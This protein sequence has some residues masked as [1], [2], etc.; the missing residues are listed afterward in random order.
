M[1]F[2][3][4]HFL[5]ASELAGAFSQFPQVE[6]IA[7]GGSLSGGIPDISSDIDLYVFTTALIPLANREAIVQK[8]GASRANLNLTFWDLGDEWFDAPSGIELDIIYWDINW[9][10]GMLDQTLVRQQAGMGY[11]TCFWR[12]LKMAQALFDRSGWLAAQQQ[13]C[14]V[15]YPET[16]R[17]DIITKNHAVL[18][19][20]IP[21][22]TFQLEKAVKRGD[23]VSINHR[24]A[25][26]LASYFDVLFAYN[27]VLHPGEKRLVPFAIQ[28]CSELP[29]KMAEDI[30]A[31]LQAAAQAQPEVLRDA[32][33]LV[34][35]LEILLSKESFNP[36]TSQFSE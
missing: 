12:T 27:R 18:R 29:I 16:L 11:T 6:A 13:R 10:S 9:I 33:R 19:R 31:A 20:V 14:Q 7:L 34:D 8:R 1:N 22:Y 32:N 17:R 26:F 15:G 5:L 4:E 25:A 21:S 30:Q 28:N 24:M 23:L 2:H 3:S 36:H 35:R